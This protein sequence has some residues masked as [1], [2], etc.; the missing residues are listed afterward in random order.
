M[1][2]KL[3]TKESIWHKILMYGLEVIGL[4]YSSY[5]AYVVDNNDHGRMNRL[6]LRIPHLNDITDDDT[7]AWPKNVWGGADYG[8]QVLPQKGDLVWVEFENGNP[9]YPI[10]SHAGY[11]QN[12]LPKEF[13]NNRCYGFK[14]PSGTLV[15]INDNKGEE[16][17]LVKHKSSS[18]WYKLIKDEFELE[19][20]IIKLGK[21][22]EEAALM[23]DTTKDKLDKILSLLETNQDILANHI[24]PTP[25][26]PSNKPVQ[27]E[28]INQV[29]TGLNNIKKSLPDILSDKVRI[30]KKQ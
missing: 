19:S 4:H 6:K 20:K 23:G 3:L 25:S 8:S 24:H 30:D 26:G 12:E 10:W 9:D 7:W 17:I 28:Q 1:S 15:M 21:K 18:D 2:K 27:S 11:A 13:K 22:G 29:K 5:R 16:E 14:T